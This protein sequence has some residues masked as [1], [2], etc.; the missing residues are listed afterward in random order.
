MKAPIPVKLLHHL[1]DQKNIIGWL[2]RDR[3]GQWHHTCKL[4]TGQ[5]QARHHGGHPPLPRQSVLAGAMTEPLKTPRAAGNS[6]VFV[7]QHPCPASIN[8]FVHF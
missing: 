8:V 1:C 3:S 2:C 6:C 7:T 4:Q 5:W